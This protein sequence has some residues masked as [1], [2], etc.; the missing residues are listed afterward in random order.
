MVMAASTADRHPTT[1][2]SHDEHGIDP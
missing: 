1:E 2:I